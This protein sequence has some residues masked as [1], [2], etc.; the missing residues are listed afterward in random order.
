M[1][2]RARTEPP[3]LWAGDGVIEIDA[4]V[5]IYVR[6]DEDSPGHHIVWHWCEPNQRWWAAN[7]DGHQVVSQDPL[8]LEPSLLWRCCGRHGFLRD[9]KWVPA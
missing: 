1:T 9:G 2:V 4:E 3:T 6:A 8:H 5:G 7:T